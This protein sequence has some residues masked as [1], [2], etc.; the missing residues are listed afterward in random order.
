MRNFIIGG[1]VIAIVLGV[2][3]NIAYF[4]TKEQVTFTVTDKDRIVETST[5][6]DGNST[7]S[8]KYLIFT[9]IETFEN[10]DELFLGKFNSS[11]LQGQLRI[12]S[13]Y[14]GTVVGWRIPFL[15]RYRNI[16]EIQ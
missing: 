8:S 9:D 4:G 7:V 14:T 5:D 11:D 1:V 2:V 3:Y 15:S 12:D 13:T 6:S 10:T 16:I